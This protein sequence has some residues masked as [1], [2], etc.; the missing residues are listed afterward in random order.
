ME[1]FY[2]Q[3]FRSTFFLISAWN[4]SNLHDVYYTKCN[5]VLTKSS[6]MIKCHE[7]KTHHQKKRFFFVFTSYFGKTPI[8]MSLPESMVTVTSNRLGLYTPKATTSSSVIS[9]FRNTPTRLFFVVSTSRMV[10]CRAFT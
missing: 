9:T 5:F 10:L 3:V 6:S 1:C 2:L 7:K 8:L 4:I